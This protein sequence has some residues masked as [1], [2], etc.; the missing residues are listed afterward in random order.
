MEKRDHK[1]KLWEVFCLASG[2]MISSG[3][4]IIAGLAFGYA[5]P[6][7]ILS[8][9]IAGLACIPTVLSMSELTSAMPKAGGD[10]FY[11]TRGFGSLVGTIAGIGSWFSL[12]FKS[13]FALIG[14]GA[15][16]TLITHYPIEVIA[17]ILCI[18]FIILNIAGVKESSAFQVFLVIGLL[19]I[20]FV[21][22]IWGLPHIKKEQITPFFSKGY[23]PVFS[24]ASFV[25][26]AYGGLTQ[27]VAMAEE[28]ENPEKNLLRGM[29]LSLLVV[30]SLYMLV[31]LVTVGVVDPERLSKTLTPISDGAYIFGGSLFEKIVSIAA[32]LAFI[33][34]VNA[35]IMSASR[36][37]LGM[38]RDKHMPE[39]FQKTN[40]KNIPY[41]A[42]L[43]TG[44]FMI[45]ALVLLKLE[46]LVKIG[47]VIFLISYILANSAVI[48]FRESK[49]TGYQPTFRSPFYPYT[50]IAGILITGF[51]ILEVSTGV[52]FLTLL[53]IC[54][55]GLIYRYTIHNKVVRDSALE[56]LLRRLISVDKELTE[57]DVSSELKEIVLSRDRIMEDSYYRKSA[58][59]VFDEII[60]N[61]SVLDINEYLKLEPFFIIISENLAKK[62]DI[63]KTDIVKK[64]MERE[65]TSSTVVEEGIAIPHLIIEGKGIIKIL[66]VRN[67]K[68]T[69]FLDGKIVNTAIV[70][71]SSLDKRKLHLKLLAYFLNMIES[72]DFDNDWLLGL[73]KD[74][75][76]KKIMDFIKKQIS[77]ESERFK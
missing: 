37:L 48:L 20:L 9:L 75:L 7:V 23:L 55:G 4:F 3:L 40:R 25:F 45:F 58:S 6:A 65:L 5:G 77:V 49:I 60:K 38:S 11:I 36:Y 66:F 21:Y 27:I 24:T 41:I 53:F 32:F 39:I 43:F 14:M 64:F 31:V 19:A 13:A 69:E 26:V 16:L 70:I 68:G 1:L 59:A 47:S 57:L 33:S 18:F 34:T 10:Y 67:K 73:D 61:I 52:L 15:Y 28:I 30:A 54:A 22:S 76:V 17:V 56:H 62:M 12:S 50:Q 72:P 42:V 51:L 29:V 63:N 35:G 46:V 2:A 8:Y 74:G 44:L 71:L